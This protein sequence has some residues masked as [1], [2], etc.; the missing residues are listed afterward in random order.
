MKNRSNKVMLKLTPIDPTI[1]TRP[2]ST[3]AMKDIDINAV[4]NSETNLWHVKFNPPRV[5]PMNLQIQFT[6]FNRLI[7]FV[8]EHYAKHNLKIEEMTDA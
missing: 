6:N 4:R 8:S 2:G 7:N 1:K 3:N 5:T